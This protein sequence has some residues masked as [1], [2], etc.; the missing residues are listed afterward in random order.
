[1]SYINGANATA[2]ETAQLGEQWADAILRGNVALAKQMDLS[3]GEIE[4][5]KNV[6]ALE[7]KGAISGE[8]AIKRRQALVLK[9]AKKFEGETVRVFQRPSG[10]IAQM[11]TQVGNVLETLGEPFIERAPEM[12]ASFKKI[13]VEAEPVA[14]ELAKMTGEALKNFAKWLEEGGA[15]TIVKNLGHIVTGLKGIEEWLNKINDAATKHDSVWQWLQKVGKPGAQEKLPGRRAS[16]RPRRIW[17]AK[18]AGV[19]VKEPRP[20]PS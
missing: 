10:K 1:M 19:T 15:S 17:A 9:F 4:L 13:A 7:K 6:T 11:W 20:G 18:P 8:E 3:T 2:E 14:R 12:A 5:I 16:N